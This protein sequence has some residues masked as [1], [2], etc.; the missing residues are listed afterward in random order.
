MTWS[1]I[2]RHPFPR[3]SKSAGRAEAVVEESNSFG[4][5]PV[6]RPWRFWFVLG[7]LGLFSA[8]G[9]AVAG[10]RSQDGGPRGRLEQ[11]MGRVQS[12]IVDV[13]GSVHALEGQTTTLADSINALDA[14]LTEQE[15]KATP[16]A[17]TKP[18]ATVRTPERRVPPATESRHES[19]ENGTRQR[20]RDA[21]TQLDAAMPA[22]VAK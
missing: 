10:V 20:V 9:G 22:P 5:I 17:K 7:A 4:Q 21:L 3:P 16:G 11:R 8:L 18:F 12:D 19:D 13:A 1:V 15:R 14:R 6:D 2:L